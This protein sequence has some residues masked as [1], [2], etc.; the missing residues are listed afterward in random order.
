MTTQP[1]LTRLCGQL[2]ALGMR[3]IVLLSPAGRGDLLAAMAWE[4]LSVHAR[5]G[6]GLA[7]AGSVEVIECASIGA[8]L[9]AVAA[10]TRR[11]SGSGAPV[12]ICAGD[13][14]GHTEALARLRRCTGTGALTAAQ[15]APHVASGPDLRPALRLSGD[16]DS[17]AQTGAAQTAAATTGVARTAVARTAAAR[18]VAARR[19]R[20]SASLLAA[21]FLPTLSAAPD[22]ASTRV[23]PWWRRAPHSTASMHPTRSAV[24]RSWS[25]RAT[26]KN[27]PQRRMSSPTWQPGDPEA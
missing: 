22:L 2:S 21:G 17:G 24:G 12:L 10:V 14:V 16:Q 26:V 11:V 9:R 20:R 18:T 1:L 13:L 4:G 5:P 25:P 6:P 8:E 23:A 27:W 19:A 3:D 7:G 15:G